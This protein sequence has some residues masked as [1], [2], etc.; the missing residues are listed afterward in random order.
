MMKQGKFYFDNM[1]STLWTQT[2]VHYAGMDFDASGM[3]QWI[4]PT[5]RPSRQEKASISNGV[6]RTYANVYIPCWADT[7][8]DVMDLMDDVIKF[9][10]SNT[11]SPFKITNTSII[12]H[13][14]DDSNKVFGI[15]MISIEHIDGT[16]Q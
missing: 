12:D 11:V 10:D 5:Y 1:F 3:P 15:V 7:D 9:V 8:V 6:T 4:N 13:G 14:W 16:C 2:P